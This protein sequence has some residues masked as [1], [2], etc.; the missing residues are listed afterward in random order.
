[1]NRQA[2]ADVLTAQQDRRNAPAEAREAARTLADPRAVA[3]VTGQQAGLFGGPLYTLLKAIT[4]LRLAERIRASTTCRSSR[5]S[6]STPRITTGTRSR[7][8]H[9][10]RRRRRASVGHGRAPP[11]GAGERPAGCAPLHGRHLASRARARRGAAADGVHARARRDACAPTTRAGAASPRR[12]AAGSSGRSAPSGSSCST[13]RTR[14]P[15]RSW[16]ICS[17]RSS[18]SRAA[19]RR[20][21]PRRAP[22]WPRAATTARSSLE[23][24][25][26]A[27]SCSIGGASADQD[28][29]GRVQ[30]GETR[31]SH[32]RRSSSARRR[33]PRR[34]ARTSCCGRWCR[35][36]SFPTICYVAGPNELAYLGQLSRSTRRFGIPMPLIQ[37]RATATVLDAA[38]RSL[39]HPL[40]GA[41]RS[42]R[43][44]DESA[45]NELL[46]AQL[47]PSVERA[48]QDAD[49]EIAARMDAMIRAVPAI[50]PTLEGA[51]RSRSARSQHDMKALRGKIVQAAKRRDETLRRQFV[52]VQRSAFPGGTPQERT[53]GFV[54]FLNR[55]GP[56]LRRAPD[57]RAADRR[58]HPLD[59]DRL[60]WMASRSKG[61]RAAGARLAGSGSGYRVPG[62]AWIVF[63]V[64]FLVC[65]VAV[66]GV[67]SY[68]WVL[69]ARQID[70]RLHGERDRVLPRVYARPFELYR[71]QAL[72]VRAAR[73]SAERPRLCRAQRASRSPA[74][75]CWT[76]R[77]RAHPAR[78]RSQGRDR[79]RDVRPAAGRGRRSRRRRRCRRR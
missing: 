79:P 28:D 78:R 46:R 3:I 58:R 42:A 12:S 10:A 62:A 57:R 32:A 74:S 24:A 71:G 37:P 39:P 61:P 48:V 6:G 19:R 34:S 44:R 23:K 72:G 65:T 60:D 7:Q 53:M 77:H 30:R 67:C 5:S 17:A 41:L 11:A 47:P 22:N 56:R 68:Y 8:L 70:A 36:R 49:A 26:S 15:S 50:D 2:I 75:S 13:A 20:W 55:Y 27:C 14:Q 33:P 59:H 1:M 45:L 31:H 29:S 51:A 43:P 4:A 73:R 25:A 38:R 9:G 69:F 16:P 64:L 52:H 18:N 21:R 40:P 35:T 66:V 63:G 76:R 54:A